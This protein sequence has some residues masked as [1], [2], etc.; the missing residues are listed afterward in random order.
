MAT[1]HQLQRAI[2]SSREPVPNIEFSIKINDKIELKADFPNTTVWAFSRD[3]TDPV[4]DQ[5][6][7]IPD[8]NF[9]NYNGVSGSFA[10]F[11]RQA[12]ELDS[13]MAQK[14]A[15]LVWR[16]TIIFNP[17]IREALLKQSKDKPWSDVRKVDEGTNDADQISH[18]LT[19]PDHCK[20]Q[21]AAH[22]E[23]TTWSGRLKY[24]LSCH[25]VAVVHK[26]TW[27]T[28]LYHLLNPSGP[29][30]NYLAVDPNWEDLP[31]KIENLLRNPDEAQRIA[32][33]AAA[34]FRDRYFTPAAQTCYWRQLMRTWRDMSFEPDPYEYK[35][36]EDG[37]V[38]KKWRGMTYE[39][40]V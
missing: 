25:A 29:D 36:Q 37:S 21:F 32:D 22:T 11:Q 24:L 17:G 23:G 28:H 14:K 2:V 15:Q 13:P 12:M 19:M 16:G 1:L 26:L 4:M 27:T 38:V 6:W 39:E 33:N 31:D 34:H 35:K 30:Q 7:L 20:Y 5:T 10:D 9:W 18:K 8:F 3:V 40:Y